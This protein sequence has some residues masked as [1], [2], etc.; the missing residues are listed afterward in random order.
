MFDRKSFFCRALPVIFALLCL[1]GCSAN[2]WMTSIPTPSQTPSAS[3]RASAVLPSSETP[4]SSQRSSAD[5]ESASTSQQQQMAATSSVTSAVPVIIDHF[6][7][8]VTAPKGYFKDA[9]FIGDSRAVGVYN[10]AFAGEADHFT[11]TSMSVYRVF[12]DSTTI[13]RKKGSTTEKVNLTQVLKEK[14]YGKIYVMLGIN[15]AGYGATKVASQMKAILQKIQKLQPGAIIYLQAN[16]HVSKAKSD[17]GVTFNNNALNALNN[18]LHALTDNRRIFWLDVNPLF[19]D[20]DGAL[21]SSCTNDGV[22]P[23]T[24]QYRQWGAWIRTQTVPVPSTESSAISSASSAP[25][26]SSEI[27]SEPPASSQEVSQ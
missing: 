8:Y 24:A 6:D 20:A 5:T 1:C 25:A 17:S 15:D 18:A 26:A 12:S 11:K 7:G 13:E 3:S 2:S 14:H 19:D 9:L 4:V 16:L 23:K 22:H 21:K 27:S 10:Y